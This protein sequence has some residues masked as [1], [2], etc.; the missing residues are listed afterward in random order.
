MKGIKLGYTIE[1][2]SHTDLLGWHLACTLQANLSVMEGVYV[3]VGREER[4]TFYFIQ[5][6]ST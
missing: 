4:S 6:P 3:N 1:K 5:K 2:D